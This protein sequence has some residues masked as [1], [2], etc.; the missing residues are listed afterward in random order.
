MATLNLTIAGF[1]VFDAPSPGTGLRARLT[2]HVQSSDPVERLWL[3]WGYIMSPQVELFPGPDYPTDAGSYT[4]EYLPHVAGN[5]TPDVEGFAPD[6]LSTWEDAI[7]MTLRMNNA[8]PIRFAGQAIDNAIAAT[9]FDDRVT[10]ND[11]DDY[12][13]GLGGAD[14]LFG[15]GDRDTLLGGA[16]QDLLFGGADADRLLGEADGDDLRG[17]AGADT[18][19]GGA[20]NDTLRGGDDDDLLEGE[21]GADT[22]FGDAG[23]DSMVGG[24]GGDV[25]WG[26]L[27]NDT[28]LGGTLGTDLDGLLG[29]DLL[30]GD[31]GDD[32]LAGGGGNDTLQGGSGNDSMEGGEGADRLN[33]GEGADRYEG[34]EGADLLIT[35]A[36]GAADR[37]VFRLATGDAIDRIMGFEAGLDRIVLAV[38]SGAVLQTGAV[39]SGAGPVILYDANY[40]HALMYDADGGGSG[41]ATP[42]ARLVGGPALSLADFDL[43]G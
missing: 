31:A 8:G 39:A 15:G 25:L 26:G 16:G 18:L 14:T 28:L 21:A 9:A 5:F 29:A 24:A 27:G 36:D 38:A 1:E 13:L 17:Q 42:F 33:G 37:F 12:I 10:G 41:A 35:T 19:L 32:L 6:Q 43:I 20:G 23:A 34:G 7:E 4:H 22:L 11:G 3:Q 30:R 40:G 2:L